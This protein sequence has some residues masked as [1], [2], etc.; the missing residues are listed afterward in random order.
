VSARQAATEADRRRAAGEHLPLL[1]VPVA[2]KDDM[3]VAGEPTAFG[4]PGPFPLKQHDSEM[5]RRLR[6]AGAVIVGKANA[7]E[8]GLYPFTEGSAFGATRNPWHLDHTPGGSSGG[9]AAAVAAGIVPAAV[10]SDGAGSV[11]IP[12]AWCGLVGVK[13][14]RGRISTWPDAESFNGLSCFGPLTRTVADAALLL[15]VLSGPHPGDLHT[16]PAPSEAFALAATRDPGRLRIAL[17]LRA[18]FSG[19]PVRLDP[20]IRAAAER[21]GRVLRDLGHEV[22]EANPRYGLMGLALVARGQAGV[23]SWV[24]GVPDRS[25]LDARTRGAARV[26]ALF[27]HT[28]LPVARRA[29]PWLQR[30]VGAIFDRVDVVITPTSAGPPLRIG[31]AEGLS[32]WATDQLIAGS[33]PY[34]WPWNVLGWPGVNVPAGLNRKGLPLGV[35]LLGSANTEATLLSLAAQLERVE[36]WHERVPPFTL[37]TPISQ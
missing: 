28:V 27:A 5:V 16:P 3:D 6:A 12:A 10:G 1:G 20:E 32:S 19:A 13:P 17:S 15:D 37:D 22:I 29:E 9:G 30:R 33:C 31:A 7:P 14:Q 25:L 23:G 11:R 4:C 21:I 26:G 24:R 8:V 2:V 18:P 35:Q 34:A 36:R